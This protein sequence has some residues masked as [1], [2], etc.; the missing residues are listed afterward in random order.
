MQQKCSFT[1]QHLFFVSLQLSDIFDKHIAAGLESLQET[2]FFVA[3]D[4]D[5]VIGIFADFR[6]IAHYFGHSRHYLIQKWL[7]LTKIAV[8]KARSPAQNLAQHI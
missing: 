5:N 7:F 6:V 8:T 2:L 4:S 3:N 1:G